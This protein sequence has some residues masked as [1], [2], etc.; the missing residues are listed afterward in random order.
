MKNIYKKIGATA[1]G[2]MVATNVMA[3]K[4]AKRCLL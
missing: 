1:V 3:L 2:V 4:R